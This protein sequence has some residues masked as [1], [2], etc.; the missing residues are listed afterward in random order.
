MPAQRVVDLV[1][2][3][4]VMP[5]LERGAPGP[6]HPG[7]EVAQPGHVQLQRRRALKERG[8]ELVAQDIHGLEEVAQRVVGVGEPIDVSDAAGGL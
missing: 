5:E 3:P 8:T 7:E 6:W 2:E 1:G 4:G